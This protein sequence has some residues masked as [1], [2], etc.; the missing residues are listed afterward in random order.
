M[1]KRNG[2]TGLRVRFNVKERRWKGE[3]NDRKNK[4]NRRGS[5]E[6]GAKGLKVMKEKRNFPHRL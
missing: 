3:K 1:E 4:Y 2:R 5:S 6:I